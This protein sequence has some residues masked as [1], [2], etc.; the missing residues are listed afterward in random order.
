MD[1]VNLHVDDLVFGSSSSFGPSNT[2]PDF[3]S[4][5]DGRLFKPYNKRDKLGKIIEFS[6]T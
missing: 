2:L 6:L 3:G 1:F 4:E 5:F